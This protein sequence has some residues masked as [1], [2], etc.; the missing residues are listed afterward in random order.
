MTGNCGNSAKKCI[1]PLYFEGCTD[2]CRCAPD[3]LKNDV[4]AGI[5]VVS[6]DKDCNIC[7]QPNALSPCD[8][9][10]WYLISNPNKIFAR[11]VGNQLICNK[12]QADGKYF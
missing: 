6:D 10:K 1:I 11:S 12:F 7:F 3:E 8:E 2:N 9:V 4:N 5:K